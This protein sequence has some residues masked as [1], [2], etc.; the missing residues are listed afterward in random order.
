M[1][2]IFFSLYSVELRWLGWLLVIA[3]FLL[4]VLPLL[5]GA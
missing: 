4:L 1:M 2:P 5:P 3:G